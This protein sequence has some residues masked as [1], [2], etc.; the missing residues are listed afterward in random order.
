MKHRKIAY[1][2][3]NM[4]DMF[5]IYGEK[6][7]H[8]G[9]Y[10][11]L[12]LGFE[13]RWEGRGSIKWVASEEKTWRKIEEEIEQ[14]SVTRAVK[15][16]AKWIKQLK[17]AEQNEEKEGMNQVFMYF[18]I[19]TATKHFEETL[20]KLI[21]IAID[22]AHAQF[23][24]R[25]K[26]IVL[27]LLEKLTNEFKEVEEWGMED[28]KFLMAE[29]NEAL[30]KGQGT[31][32]TN[33]RTAFKEKNIGKFEQIFERLGLRADIKGEYRDRKALMSLTRQ[34]QNLNQKLGSNVTQ[35]KIKQVLSELEVI[36]RKSEHVLI[37]MYRDAHLVMKRDAILMT[38]IL[39]DQDL[40][41][42]LGPK[43]VQKHFMPEV[44]IH[45]AE[46]NVTALE[47][48]LSKKA[49]GIGNGLNVI[50]KQMKGLQHD[51]EKEMALTAR[52]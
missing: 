43:W 52:R 20:A 47:E 34:L 37:S 22:P 21:N 40:I 25:I 17:H 10:F 12:L 32:I 18:H 5:G 29:M 33:V 4:G 24:D 2:V 7:K 27:P 26:G 11:P 44:P 45:R 23:K 30:E 51:F 42:V 14:H 41:H 6:W 35:L 19:V 31:F 3:K 48:G 28:L 8:L 15:D 36:L 38:I 9:A 50:L 49:H 16:I 46:L 39:H 1:K 13:Q